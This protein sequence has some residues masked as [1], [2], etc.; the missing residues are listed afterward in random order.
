MMFSVKPRENP[1]LA[2]LLFVDFQVH[3]SNKLNQPQ[4][5]VCLKQNIFNCFKTPIISSPCL[6]IGYYIFTSTKPEV[7]KRT[8]ELLKMYF[9]ALRDLIERL[10]D[11]FPFTFEVAWNSIL[12]GE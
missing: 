8:K 2:K 6:D 10:G 1:E 5:C 7:R 12:L 11:E 3:L 4:N 9:D